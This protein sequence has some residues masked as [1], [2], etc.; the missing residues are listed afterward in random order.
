MPAHHRPPPVLLLPALL[1]LAL[2]LLPAAAGATTYVPMSDAALAEGAPVIVEGRVLAVE[3]APGERPAID[4]LVQVE[5]SIRGDLPPGALVV[6][7]P[8][9]VRPDGVGLLLRGAPRFREGEEV[10]LFLQ[11]RRDGTFGLYQFLL[12]AFRLENEAG[13]RV[14]RRDLTDARRLMVPGRPVPE[15][16]PRDAAG[17][18]RWLE[19]RAG[20]QSPRADYFLPA[21][22]AGGEETAGDKFT[23]VVSTDDP[24]PLGCGEDG[25]HSVRWF[26]F[27][28]GTND[29]PWHAHYSGQGG[30]PGNGI[31]AFH[32]ALAAWNDDPNTPIRYAFAGLTTATAGLTTTDGVNAILFDDPNDEIAGSFDGQGMLALGGPWFD[33]DLFAHEGESFHPIVAG[34]IV[35][36]D[37][38]DPFFSVLAEPANAAEQLFAHELGHTLGLGHSAEPEA[39]MFEV[40]HSDLRG[41]ALDVDDLAGLLYLYGPRD[42]AP[43]AAPSE[44][45]ATE[46]VRHAVTLTW[47]DNSDDESVFRIERREAETFEL[48]T[49]ADADATTFIDSGIEPATLYAYRLAAV[50]G[51]GESAATGA[52][53]I[54]TA[55]DLRPAAP[56]NLRGAP[57]SSTEIRLSWQ[58]NAC[59]EDAFLVE[60]L[61]PPDWV[62]IPAEL[63]PNTRKLIVE[64]LPPASTISFRLRA[65]NGFGTSDASNH[66][67]AT[68]FEDDDGCVVTGD[69]LCLLGG[70]FKIS[71]TYRNQYDGGSEGTATAI[72]TTDESGLFWFSGPQNVELI[73]KALDGRGFNDHYWLFY[74]ALSDLEYWVTVTDTDT[75]AV[76]TY[77]NPPGEICGLAD[78][79]AFPE[80]PLQAG[81]GPPPSPLKETSEAAPHRLD[82]TA[83]ALKPGPRTPIGDDPPA[84]VGS[85]PPTSGTCEPGPWTLC[86]LGR[87]LAVEV[88]VKNQYDGGVEGPGRA[89]A[90]SD[91]SG[92]F[93]FFTIDNAELV[94]KALD[95]G[96]VNEHLWFFY[97]ALTDLEYWITVTDT[98]TGDSSVYYNPPGE[99]CGRADTQAFVAVPP[100]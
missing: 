45:T 60:I 29:V 85:P 21:A 24:F 92:L 18:R 20:G 23:T 56:T 51:A 74:G 70:R 61:I 48:V 81:G 52:V 38:L 26:D 76:K 17:F 31:G 100:S 83:L 73:V 27:Q 50:N 94:V 41:A 99:V 9:G 16:G 34:D 97:G 5:H 54:L 39:L 36:Q 3:A 87:R 22:Q 96:A 44:L 64:G 7:V 32:S 28:A 93:W 33:C 35:V 37:G 2:W 65:V 1:L 69:E 15:D 30:V 10:L 58:D 25:G 98:A 72:P 59:D 6:R 66:A 55:E 49:T 43:P 79:S 95:G 91:N 14:A 12:G 77:H 40:Y 84:L 19:A 42:L 67:T 88:W 89:I 46:D 47:R 90:D 8:G 80:M 82:V 11:P 71:A 86:L 75:D 53:E 13:A 4:Y 68:T 63:P 57:L 78:T 62:E